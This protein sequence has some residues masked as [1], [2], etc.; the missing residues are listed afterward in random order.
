MYPFIMEDKRISSLD[1]L[2][3]LVLIY[4]VFV[5]AFFALSMK[6][7]W[8]L[9]HDGSVMAPGDL[10]VIYFFLSIGFNL[11]LVQHLRHP[12]KGALF[13]YGIKR[14]LLIMFIGIVLNGYTMLVAG[15]MP[16]LFF[17]SF[18]FLLGMAMILTVTVIVVL[19]RNSLV[20]VGILTV[21]AVTL[22]LFEVKLPAGYRFLNPYLLITSLGGYLLGQAYLNSRQHFFRIIGA[23]IPIMIITGAALSFVNGEAPSRKIMNESYFFISWGCIILVM[24]LFQKMDEST[25]KRF[26]QWVTLLGK[27]PL[28]FWII[29]SAVIA[30]S[31][32]LVSLV[33]LMRQGAFTWSLNIPLLTQ[34]VD[35][36]M[37]S[38]AASVLAG[39]AAVGATF[40]WIFA[41]NRFNSHKT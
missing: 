17:R 19:P 39:A 26:P 31:V 33:A 23:C 24:A 18:L 9:S 37:S 5:N 15:F 34:S 10:I 12:G 41:K 7:P 36:L 21:T 4:M 20:W 1:L 8:L 30:G 28:S 13:L 32:L 14:G 6:Q 40:L 29:Q 35:P 27:H 3:G 25:V 11:S 2:R 38:I 22:L 16:V